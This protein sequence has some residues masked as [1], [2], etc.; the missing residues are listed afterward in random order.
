MVRCY[1]CGR[2]Y[3]GHGDCP[4]CE[5]DRRTEGHQYR[6]EELA[7]ENS[8][9]SIYNPPDLGKITEGLDSLGSDIIA[10]AAVR[11]VLGT[12]S[13]RI[14]IARERGQQI[15][16]DLEFFAVAI[17]ADAEKRNIRATFEALVDQI[18]PREYAP[19][20]ILSLLQKGILLEKRDS[21]TGLYLQ[22]NCQSEG[23]LKFFPSLRDA[24]SYC[25]LEELVRR[26]KVL[27]PDG[28]TIDGYE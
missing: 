8:S 22:V 15:K 5:R 21:S 7:K 28:L 3:S 23:L 19:W 6:L 13:E 27:Y 12:L 25:F 11:A 16:K 26:I 24:P 14:K 17:V 9:T 1:S 4:G 18:Q 20:A 2:S 10:A